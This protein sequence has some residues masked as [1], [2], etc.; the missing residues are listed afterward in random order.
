MKNRKNNRWVKRVLACEAVAIIALLAVLILWIARPADVENDQPQYALAESSAE[1]RMEEVSTEPISSAPPPDESSQEEE[2]PEARM[3]LGAVGDIMFHEWQLTRAYRGGDSFDFTD[4]FSAIAPQ[5]QEADFAVANLETVFAGQ[6]QGNPT[7]EKVYG[8]SS[9]PCFNTPSQAAVNIRDAGFDFLGTANNH[10]LDANVK[11]L[12]STLEV[13]REVGIPS[14]GSYSEVDAPRASVQEVNGFRLGFLAY[15]Y[16]ANGF[17]L[18]ADQKGLLN[19]LEDYDADKINAMYEETEKLAKSGEADL[20]IVM[21]HFG[22]EYQYTPNSTQ[23]EMV[24]K[25]F[26]A[27]ADIILGSHPHVLQ[28]F[29]VREIVNEDGTTRQGF[30][31][32]SLGNFI[33]SQYYTEQRPYYKELGVYIQF[34]LSKRGEEKPTL[35][36]VSLMP[37]YVQWKDEYIRVVPVELAIDSYDNGGNTYDLTA[38]DHTKITRVQKFFQTSFWPEEYSYTLSDGYYVVN[39]TEPG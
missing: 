5:I 27:G 14:T 37:T 35:E 12:L 36:S 17:T 11:G 13:L 6:N 7:S 23:E 26:E 32:Y 18:P 38:S 19:M 4:S 30:V 31:I 25:L 1:S 8:Y 21:M 3:V 2:I 22:T 10:S 15:T 20:V 24:D 39:L 16:G 28:P 33:S 9:Y 34:Q 29:E